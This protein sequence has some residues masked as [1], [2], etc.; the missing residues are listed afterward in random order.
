MIAADPTERA[1]LSRVLERAAYWR[2][3]L[4]KRLARLIVSELA[5]AM[6]RGRGRR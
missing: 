4:D 1:T 2:L 6:K 5:E 3:E